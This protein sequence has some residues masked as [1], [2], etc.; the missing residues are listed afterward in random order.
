[1]GAL[2]LWC[3]DKAPRDL[4]SAK[5]SMYQACAE[6]PAEDDQIADVAFARL[7]YDSAP[8]VVSPPVSLLASRVR[9]DIV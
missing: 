2:H 6:S 5:C 3:T 9:W 7:S 1:M 4:S 8:F